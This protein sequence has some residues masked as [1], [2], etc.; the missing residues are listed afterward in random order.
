MFNL[1]PFWDRIIELFRRKP[2][3]P[4]IVYVV[5]YLV[6]SGGSTVWAAG[7]KTIMRADEEETAHFYGSQTV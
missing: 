2:F 4:D 3:R 7:G 5:E 1:R 6:Y